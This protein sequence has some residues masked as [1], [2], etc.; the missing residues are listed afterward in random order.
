M[1]CR[2][3]IANL[4]PPYI[5]RPNLLLT[6]DFLLKQNSVHSRFDSPHPVHTPSSIALGEIQERYSPVPTFHA[7]S[8]ADYNEDNVDQIFNFQVPSPSKSVEISDSA[9]APARVYFDSPI[10]DPSSSDP[11]EPEEYGY[12]S[13]KL[14]E[15]EHIGFRW[16]AFDRKAV[17][18]DF[19]KVKPTGEVIVKANGVIEV[20]KVPNLAMACVGETV[21]PEQADYIVHSIPHVVTPVSASCA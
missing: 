15:L 1:D 19:A 16:T 17:G 2:D 12:E 21:Q 20:T 5:Y 14:E 11:M 9:R 10:E 3:K 18:I 4:G 7:S 8:H 6:D 13:F